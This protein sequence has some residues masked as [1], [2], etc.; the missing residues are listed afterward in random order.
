MI[1]FDYNLCLLSPHSKHIAILPKTIYRYN[2]ISIR[3]PTQLFTELRR[4]ILSTIWK[5]S[6]PRRAKIILNNKSSVITIPNFKLYY[7]TRITRTALYCYENRYVDQL[8]QIEDPDINL[9]IYGHLIFG[10]ARNSCCKK[11]KHLQINGT[12]H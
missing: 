12:G 11:R 6:K 2:G 9:H 3:I 10:K 8:N 1:L 4:T 7:K 5:H